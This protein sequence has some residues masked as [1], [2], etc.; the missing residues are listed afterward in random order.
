MYHF[1]TLNEGIEL[2]DL[3]KEHQWLVKLLHDGRLKVN[4]IFL[5]HQSI[6]SQII[7]CS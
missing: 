6:T 1:A 2:I 7:T 3:G 4:L 5:W